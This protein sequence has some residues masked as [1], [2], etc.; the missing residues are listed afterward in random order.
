MSDLNSNANSP[1]EDEKQ[2]KA[3]KTESLESKL[4]KWFIGSKV[5]GEKNK[6][7]KVSFVKDV[8]SAT[9]VTPAM[10]KELED[11]GGESSEFDP[12][13]Y[14]KLK[15]SWL[16]RET[17]TTFL[18]VASKKD[19]IKESFLREYN[20]DGKAYDSKLQKEIDN[21]EEAW[22]N[23]L[24]NSLKS[25]K[26]LL[27]KVYWKNKIP[28]TIEFLKTLENLDFSKR[29]QDKLK[30]LTWEEHDDLLDLA[31]RFSSGKK[32]DTVDIMTLFELGFFT[33]EEKKDI[34]KT[35]LPNINLRKA[36]E[37]W[38]ITQSQL[39]QYKQ[40]FVKY[41]FFDDSSVS[42]GEIIS[43]ANK[44]NDSDIEI[45]TE[46]AL[47]D[48]SYFDAVIWNSNLWYKIWQSISWDI[49][50]WV[51]EI[52]EL[53]KEKDAEKTWKS[54]EW[55]QED[56]KKIWSVTNPEN[57]Q[58]GNI[59]IVNAYETVQWEWWKNSIETTF[60]WDILNAWDKTAKVE[61]INRWQDVYN[62]S[63]DSFSRNYK[64]ILDFI[65]KWN[66]NSW[67][68][69]KE[70]EIITKEELR[71][72]VDSGELK[73]NIDQLEL[74][75]SDYKGDEKEKLERKQL[76]RKD[77]LISEWVD[78]DKIWDDYEFKKL[79][80][81][82]DS[83]E[84]YNHNYLERKINEDIDPEGKDFWIEDN[85]TFE[86]KEGKIFTIHLVNKASNTIV[87]WSINW[88]VE[89]PMSFQAFFTQFKK[90]NCK[91]TSNATNFT[92]LFDSVKES[93]WDFKL[94]WDS[95][96]K[97]STDHNIDYDY[98]IS[99]EDEQVFRIDDVNGWKVKVTYWTYDDKKEVD[100]ETW[101]EKP[102]VKKYSMDT[103]SYEISV[104]ALE[105]FI[106]RFNLEP[107]SVDEEKD[108]SKDEVKTPEQG[109]SFW[110]RL[111]DRNFSV[112][113]I[114]AWW[115]VWVESFENYL[116]E[117]NDEHAAKFASGVLGRFLPKE[118]K[119][120][121]KT[122]VETA[123]KKRMDDYVEKLKNVDS[124]IATETIERRL[125]NKD[126]PQYKLEAAVIFMME[127]YWTLY[128]KWPLYKY[129]WS[130]IWYKALWWEL[131]DEL[132]ND[133]KKEHND[134][135][136][137]FNEEHL[138]FILIKLQ[139]KKDWFQNEV[140][141]KHVKRRTRLHKEFKAVRNKAKEEE[142][143]KGKKDAAGRRTIDSRLDYAIW[144]LEG[145]TYA[146]AM[147]AMESIFWKGWN[148][149]DINALPIIMSFSWLWYNMDEDTL[150]WIK[151]R[152]LW[153]G[154]MVPVSALMS[155][156]SHMDVFNETILQLSKDLEE[157]H[158]VDC[159]WMAE[160]AKEISSHVDD[161]DHWWQKKNK[162]PS[163]QRSEP[164]KLEK[165]LTF[166]KK[167]WEY[168]TWSLNQ[169]NSWPWKLAK[170]NKILQIRKDD[171]YSEKWNS[172]LWVDAWKNS[173]RDIYKK[174]LDLSWEMVTELWKYTDEDA[175]MQSIGTLWT[176]WIDVYKAT[177]EVLYQDQGWGFRNKNIWPMIWKEI[178]T[179]IDSIIE[180]NITY[181][182]GN[183]AEDRKVKVKILKKMLRWLLA[184]LL[185]THWTRD[186]AFFSLNKPTSPFAS[187]FNKWWIDT[188]EIAG[189]S[190]S[191]EKMLD[192]SDTSAN[193]LLNRYIDDMLNWVDNTWA[194]IEEVISSTENTVA[195]IAWD[196]NNKEI[197]E[198]D[199]DE[200]DYYQ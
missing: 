63:S 120:D 198:D 133:Q 165:T 16:Q 200:L 65:N 89:E 145:G 179:Q 131:N 44:L 161:T 160:M 15:I 150:D 141:W 144:E 55:F 86:T 39:E 104:W 92:E 115:K 122:R 23:D 124:G 149:T 85:V 60:Y 82:I 1:E 121:M 129:K 185:E 163:A 71:K 8:M 191:A 171:F 62:S 105:S 159:L 101:E 27:E 164:I 81:E 117:W 21:L 76:E 199:K 103:N 32:A 94:K 11:Y 57:F 54:L 184:W 100:K 29:V 109:W 9:D 10:K 108:I 183:P 169:L 37:L 17:R 72:R 119:E 40:K 95:I 56:L 111:F 45:S 79:W 110:N 112:S 34:V 4:I 188:K 77:Q 28:K 192:E 148:L 128:A 152:I 174:Y 175:M 162:S 66:E 178:Y 53:Q 25:R 47:S 196:K 113:E 172:K 49:E 142:W 98:L 22:L 181:V 99:K 146:N 58:N 30:K 186:S 87:V 102:K 59:I 194:A 127:K 24:S 19:K 190:L 61:F 154:K 170:S 176:S 114:I 97:E 52:D 166:Y 68:K 138:V 195:D 31:N 182:E 69:V 18:E 136:V 84:Y 107:R 48:D 155:K 13:D 2:N 93:W 132:Y 125:F 156:T 157:V 135:W 180:N 33:M 187:R 78:P 26:T 147:W 90:L 70:F 158:P 12:I 80:E 75:D 3:K 143:E 153:A 41:N 116:K 42:N 173:W 106:N 43:I 7:N 20:I 140:N 74:K 73:E 96:Q 67:I 118:L 197:I 46:K 50:K 193:L 130:F 91:R 35:Y 167:Y 168:L 36:K 14:D 139:C 177:K 5:N 137:N 51:E 151:N 38:I 6:K 64:T 83:I 88:V 134:Y 126:T 189:K 123:W